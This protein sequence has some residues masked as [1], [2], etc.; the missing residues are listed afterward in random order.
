MIVLATGSLT[1]FHPGFVIGRENWP[2]AGWN[3]GRNK[4]E[5]KSMESSA[6]WWKRGRKTVINEKVGESDSSRGWSKR[7][8]NAASGVLKKGANAGEA[9]LLVLVVGPERRG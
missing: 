2:A 8:S 1:A 4:G 9:L 7:E 3:A 6:K 5:P